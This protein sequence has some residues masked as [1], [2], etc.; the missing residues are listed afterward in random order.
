MSQYQDL[1]VTIKE[2][3]LIVTI[4]K[5]EKLNILSQQTLTELQTAM[6]EGLDDESVRGFVITGSGEKA[7]A[8]GADIDEFGEVNE[9]NGRKFSERG[10]E[11]FEIIENSNKPVIAAVNGLALGGGCELAISCHFR[12]LSEK[13]QFGLPEAAL[14]IIPAFGGTQRLPRL[15]GRSKALELMLTGD[16]IEAYQAVKIGLANA[17]VTDPNELIS[18]CLE[19]HSKIQSKAPLAIA[20][21]IEAVNAGFDPE[22]NGFEVEAN[23]FSSCC[24]TSDFKEGVLAFKE[25]RQ[26]QFK[27]A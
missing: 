14:G 27:G 26:A 5:V 19:I 16:R 6:E 25:K 15:I 3:V 12:V 11:T 9:L 24:G 10:Q 17:V 20:R 13:A 8:A 22:T 23:S 21:I 4:S 1:Q 7:F 18:K 2:D